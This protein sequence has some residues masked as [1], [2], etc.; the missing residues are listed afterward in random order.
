MAVCPREQYK[1]CLSAYSHC[2][3]ISHE[4]S[5][6]PTHEFNLVNFIVQYIYTFADYMYYPRNSPVGLSLSFLTLPTKPHRPLCG[7]AQSSDSLLVLPHQ[8]AF[9]LNLLPNT[10]GDTPFCVVALVILMTSPPP[11]P[12]TIKNHTSRKLVFLSCLLLSP[13]E[14]GPPPPSRTLKSCPRQ[15][16]LFQCSG[17]EREPAQKLNQARP[18]SPPWTTPIF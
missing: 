5:Y 8:L 17:C 18:L 1:T 10:G 3:S 4:P 15:L 11:S 13:A 9:V 7:S 16:P 14:S 12:L 2:S 6:P